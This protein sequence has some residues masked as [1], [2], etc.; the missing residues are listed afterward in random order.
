VEFQ[1]EEDVRAGVRELFNCPR[2]FGGKELAS[3]FEKPDC[4]A[5]LLG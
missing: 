2:T 3:D 4:P 5:K 1:I